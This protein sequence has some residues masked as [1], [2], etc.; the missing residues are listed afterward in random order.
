MCYKCHLKV[1]SIKMCILMNSVL[2]AGISSTSSLQRE[3][4]EKKTS[5]FFSLHGLTGL[6]LRACSQQINSVPGQ[7]HISQ[8]V[9]GTLTVLQVSLLPLKLNLG[10][11]ERQLENLV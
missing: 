9:I 6:T 8:D 7:H 3:Q 10:S 1:I 4:Q 11:Q 5:P 2:P